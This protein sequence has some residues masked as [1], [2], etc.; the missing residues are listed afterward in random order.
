[1]LES[2]LVTENVLW[3]D[4]FDLLD[5]SKLMITK[6]NNLFM[7]TYG[8]DIQLKN[9]THL[10]WILFLNKNKNGNS[11]KSC[12]LYTLFLQCFIIWNG[13][14]SI[15]KVINFHFFMLFSKRKYSSKWNWNSFFFRV[16]FSVKRLC[17]RGNSFSSFLTSVNPAL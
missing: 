17:L 15:W 3:L 2:S 13:L 11:I 7:R 4:F 9:S 10:V 6:C 14:T 16:V 1:M 8:L 5:R 12:F